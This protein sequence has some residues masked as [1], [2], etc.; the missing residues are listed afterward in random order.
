MQTPTT[1]TPD[2]TVL[3][4]EALRGWISGTPL[5][6]WIEANPL[7]APTLLLLALVL[8]A[9]AAGRIARHYLLRG[10]RTLVAATPFTWDDLLVE[11]GVFDRLAWVAP[12]VVVYYGIGAVPGIPG[13]MAD[14]VARGAVALIVLVGVIAAGD[15]LDVSSEVY[16]RVNPDHASRPIKGYVQVVKLILFLV[17]GILVVAILVNR[18]PIYFLS[19]LG[20]LTA[21]LLLV[22]RDTILSF[23]AS[24]QIASNDML[25]VGDWIEMPKYGADGDVV[26]I[27]LHTVKV[28]NWDRTI[29]TI[30]T[31]RLIEDSFRNWRG[32]TES[33]GRRIKRAI[34][35][36]AGSVRFLTGEEIEDLARHELL[37][38]YLR[39]KRSAI[40]TWNARPRG[41]GVVPAVR[42]L[43]NLGTFRAYV[44]AYLRAHPNVHQEMTLLVR[45][46][47]PGAD[48]IPLEVYCFTNDIRWGAYEGI[49]GDIFDH[50]FSILPTFGLR[51]F[52]SPSGSDVRGAVE[53]WASTGGGEAAGVPAPTG[54]RT[55][56][57]G[58]A[59]QASGS[60]GGTGA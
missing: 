12:A 24:L 23:V 39:R 26:D 58:G 10:I 3:P 50:L 59:S 46:L 40:E 7:W 43:T 35:L 53:A 14:L 5:A 45:Q 55:D 21:V 2:T 18:S 54:P 31:Y 57:R 28:Q 16:V 37:R 56:D 52:Q 20:A 13:G 6:A 22:F 9:W 30:P 32:M 1:A 42:R 8:V 38:D 27:A 11:H 34:H 4:G 44:E 19:G 25:R 29:T 48:G 60:G 51:A 47:A 36:D 15:L 41:E 17:A 49:Q 33:G